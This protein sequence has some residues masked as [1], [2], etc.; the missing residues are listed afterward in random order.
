MRGDE[1]FL[2]II[3][4]DDGAKIKMPSASGSLHWAHDT[5]GCER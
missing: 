3:I 5:D 4:L 2:A 1:Q